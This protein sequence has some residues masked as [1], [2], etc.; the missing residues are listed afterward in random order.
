[1]KNRKYRV[2]K[3]WIMKN[4]ASTFDLKNKDIILWDGGLFYIKEEKYKSHK[5]IGYKKLKNGFVEVLFSK[6]KIVPRE[7]YKA[8]MWFEDLDETINYFIRMKKML[9]GLGYKT[10][11]KIK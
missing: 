3:D 8:V 7:R 9:N 2:I 11:M 1:M 10:N 5:I 4:G 6:K